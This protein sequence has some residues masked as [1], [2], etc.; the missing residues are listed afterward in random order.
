LSV[1]VNVREKARQAKRKI[2][3]PEGHDERVIKAAAKI[4]EL[5]LAVPVVLGSTITIERMAGD[6]DISM[7]GVEILEVEKAANLEEWAAEFAKM[8]EKKGLTFEKAREILVKEPVFY[9]AM[10][11]KHGEAHGVVSGATSPTAQVIRAG[12]QII[13]TK[14]GIKTVSSSFIMELTERQETYGEV[15]LFADCAVIPV[16]TSEQLADIAISTV[17]TARNIAG[18]EGKVALMTFSTKGSADHP[19]IDIVK[20]AGKILRERNVDF[21]FDDELQADAAIVKSV[22]MKKAPDSPVAGHA[23][24]LVFPNLAAGNIGY[25]LV[26]RLAGANAYGPIIQGLNNPI[27]DLSR[28]CSADDIVDLVAMTAIQ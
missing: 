2:V 5:G 14:P 23:N 16:P 7:T 27:N 28:G 9:A 11:V 20:E 8:R 17:E 3:L 21:Q 13:G 26:Q 22:A 4:V 19:D 6:L 1:L 24:I 18:I 12:L 15:I 25:K 10:M